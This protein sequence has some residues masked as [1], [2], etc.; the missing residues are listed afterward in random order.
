MTNTCDKCK[1]V[2]YC[3]T[4]CKKKHKK[5]HKRECEKRV[6]EL[7]SKQIEQSNSNRDNGANNNTDN[8]SKKALQKRE[9]AW[10][11]V[12]MFIWVKY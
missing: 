8:E 4:L 10:Q 12:S 2:K 1:S 11:R 9:E 5:K 7:Q 3:N 6:A